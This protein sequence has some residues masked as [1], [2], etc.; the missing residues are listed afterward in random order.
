MHSFAIDVKGGEQK[1]IAINNKGEDC[2][3]QI[4]IDVN[5]AIFEEQTKPRGAK[6]EL[7]ELQRSHIC[8]CHIYMPKKR[9]T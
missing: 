2:W 7:S 6:I 5:M 8:I 9:S 3:T 1:N 4:V